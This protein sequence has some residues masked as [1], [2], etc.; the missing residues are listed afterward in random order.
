MTPA[1]KKGTVIAIC[2]QEPAEDGSSM[3]FGPLK[4]DDIRFLHQA[5]I[6]DTITNAFAIPDVDVFL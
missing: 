2:I 6:T 3:D 4:G 1:K 5:F